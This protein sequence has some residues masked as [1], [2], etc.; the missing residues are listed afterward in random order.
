ML[1]L[2]SVYKIKINGG[3]GGGSGGGDG[4][5]NDDDGDRNNSVTNQLHD[6]RALLKS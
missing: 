5:G 4:G 1:I 2:Y 6:A 3:G